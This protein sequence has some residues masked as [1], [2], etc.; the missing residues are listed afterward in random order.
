M[1]E[2]EWYEQIFMRVQIIFIYLMIN[3]MSTLEELKT[4][5]IQGAVLEF[6]EIDNSDISL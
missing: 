4:F 3:I 2:Y 5:T 1:K 6:L